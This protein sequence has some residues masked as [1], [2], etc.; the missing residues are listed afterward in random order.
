[1]HSSHRRIQI[2][3][4]FGVRIVEVTEAIHGNFIYT[5]SMERLNA[6]LLCDVS[7][8][9]TDTLPPA[10]SDVYHVTMITDSYAVDADRY[11]QL[12]HSQMLRSMAHHEVA[13]ILGKASQTFHHAFQKTAP[14]KYSFAKQDPC[15][16]ATHWSLRSKCIVQRTCD[17]PI[18]DDSSI[19]RAYSTSYTT[20]RYWSTI[21]S[22]E[23]I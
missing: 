13:D 12:Q 15:A 4:L 10:F 19:T 18:F 8:K 3:M 16:N 9:K 20:V 14:A 11:S 22:K 1:M 23:V 21:P 2:S 5:T 6:L 17:W 7:S